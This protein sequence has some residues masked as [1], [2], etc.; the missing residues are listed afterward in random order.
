M[1][2]TIRILIVDDHPV[3][4]E[5]LSGFLR[6]DREFEVV[7][8]AKDGAEAVEQA[9]RLLPDIVLMDL[10]LPEFDGAEAMRRIREEN[11]DTKFIVLTT[12]DTKE[13]I[14]KAIEAGAKAFLLKDAPRQEVCDAIRAV[15]RGESLLQPTVASKVVNLVAELSQRQQPVDALS[16]RELEVLNL[17]AKGMSN[18]NIALELFIGERTVKAHITN[19]F[20]KLGVSDRTEAVTHALQKGIITLQ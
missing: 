20:Q 12:Y 4:R 7:G 1:T 8:E 13:H 19:I 14:L 6:Q 11:E 5:G 16:E 10:Q 17:M 9:K 18:K 3:V 2:Q 15:H